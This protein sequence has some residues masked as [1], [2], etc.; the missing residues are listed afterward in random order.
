MPRHWAMEKRIWAIRVT[1]NCKILFL[2]YEILK[3]ILTFDAR[4][5]EN[6]SDF[7]AFEV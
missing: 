6:L 1:M 2:Y 3:S 4:T 5:D 7:R